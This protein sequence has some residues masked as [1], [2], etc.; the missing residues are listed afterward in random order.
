MVNTKMGFKNLLF[1]FMLNSIP[2][3]MI[4]DNNYFD[5]TD[6]KFARGA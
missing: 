5:D 1:I 6:Q 2:Q 4:Y 3:G